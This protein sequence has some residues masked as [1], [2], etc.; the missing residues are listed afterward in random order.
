MHSLQIITLY[1]IEVARSTILELIGYCMGKQ[2]H[3]GFLWLAFGSI[4]T[5][6]VTLNKC[7]TVSNYYYIPTIGVS[8]HLHITQMM[9]PLTAQLKYSP[10]LEAK[11]RA[12]VISL[13]NVCSSYTRDSKPCLIFSYNRMCLRYYAPIGTHTYIKIFFAYMQHYIFFLNTV[14]HKLP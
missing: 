3:I 10:C 6:G 12:T 7:F 11:V 2:Y 9:P 5:V 8:I 13:Q 1:L 14:K 4:P